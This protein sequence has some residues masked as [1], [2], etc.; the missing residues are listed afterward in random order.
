MK[1]ILNNELKTIQ[2]EILIDFAKFCDDNKITYFIAYGSLIGA[3][4]HKGFIPWDDDID[5]VMPRKDYNK[6]IQLY[7]TKKSKFRISTANN[8]NV[9]FNYTFAKIENTDTVLIEN[10][11]GNVGVN[12]DVFPLDGLPKNF[13]LSY[14]Q[15]Y[16]CKQM[17]KIIGIKRIVYNDSVGLFRKVL[18][19]IIQSILCVVPLR[20]IISR[21]NKIAQKYSY[22]DHEFV[23]N[24]VWGTYY[25]KERLHKSLFTERTNVLFENHL[26]AAPTKYDII[27]KQIYGDY[28]R[29][30]TIDKQI[31]H[32]N[33]K[34]Y[35]K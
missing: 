6:A 1:E 30:P 18:L 20:F 16:K 26:F 3:V 8:S 2:L 10:N 19:I 23:A 17:R 27:L 29:L 15:M 24:L 31:T 35:W 22:D 12:I 14:I 28:M 25:K 5:V 33:F 32:H 4:R 7:N 34:A 13:I 11:I 21:L 9:Q